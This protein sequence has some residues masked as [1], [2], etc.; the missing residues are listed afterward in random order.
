MKTEQSKKV[1]ECLVQAK[2]IEGCSA[3][4]G[5]GPDTWEKTQKSIFSAFSSA[6]VSPHVV[7]GLEVQPAGGKHVGAALAGGGV[8][9]VAL[10]RPALVAKQPAGRGG[11]E[12]KPH[13]LAVSP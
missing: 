7:P 9:D 11:E 4:P 10:R 1:K 13:I 12:I 5:W 3:P 8:V 6:L 2:L